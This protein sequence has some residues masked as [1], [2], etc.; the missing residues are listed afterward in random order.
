M[1][2]C[3]R[4]LNEA[5]FGSQIPLTRMPSSGVTWTCAFRFQ[6]PAV[7]KQPWVSSPP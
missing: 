1:A 6:L 3:T 5:S 7:P 4:W 2:A